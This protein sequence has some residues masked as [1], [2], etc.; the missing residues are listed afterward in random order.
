MRYLRKHRG[1][2]SEL[3]RL[4]GAEPVQHALRVEIGKYL[5]RYE[6]GSRRVRASAAW[7]GGLGMARGTRSL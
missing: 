5:G 2:R 3:A 1:G 4:G 6:L 7:R